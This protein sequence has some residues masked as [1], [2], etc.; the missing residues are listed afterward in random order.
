MITRSSQVTI[1]NYSQKLFKEISI[2]SRS[3][4]RGFEQALQPLRLLWALLI[5]VRYF[6]GNASDRRP[7]SAI[8]LATQQFQLV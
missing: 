5:G 1:R 4:A 3:I 8:K 7:P 2:K 6:K